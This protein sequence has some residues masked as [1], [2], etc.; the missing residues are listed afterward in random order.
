MAQNQ[1][2]LVFAGD[3][4]KLARSFKHVDTMAKGTEGN[5]EKSSKRIGGALKTLGA[6]AATGLAVASTAL[7]GFGAASVNSARDLAETQSAVGVVFGKTSSA[8]LAF[9]VA[10][11]KTL[12]QSQTQ[13]LDAANT[14]ATFGKSA[15]L[16]GD[17]LVG[18]STKMVGLASDMASFKNTTPQEAIE[19]I[20]S[21]L[22]GE[23]EP[24]RRYG[25]LLD[26]ATLRQEAL[27][28][29]L[30]KTTKT[31]LTPQQRVLAAQ[32][33]ILKQTSDAQGDFARTSGGLANQQRIAAAAVTNLKTRIGTAL[34]P[35]VTAL[36]VTFNAKLIPVLNDL[37][38]R[39]G[40]AVTAFFADAA[41]K[42]GPLADRLGSVDWSRF[43][44]TL[45]DALGRVG[46]QLRELGAAGGQGLWDTLKVGAVVLKFLA[47]HSDLLAKALPAIV[48]GF[49]LVKGA[50]AAAN[51]VSLASIPLR[52]AEV[53]ASFGMRGALRAHTVALR[54]NTVAARLSA[55][56]TVA[57]TT[58][59]TGG[60]L[61]RTRAIAS[62]V[63]HRV[64]SIASTAV[65]WLWAAATTA[66][67]VAMRFALGP[68]GLI[69]T[70]IALLVGAI[71]WV[72]T[73]TTWFQT[74]WKF[75]WGG[76]KSA[77]VAV[78]EWIKALPGNIGKAFANLANIITTPWRI[79]FNS[80]ARLWNNT[81]GGLS[82]RVPDWIPGVGGKGFDV[83]NIPTFHSGGVV[84]GPPGA[85]VLTLLQAGERVT[86]A[87]SGGGTAIVVSGG[88]GTSTERAIV[89]L[90]LHLIRTGKLQLTVQN[91]RVAV[92][93]G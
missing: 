58:A 54:E 45:A 44:N 61:A 31:A 16:S 23:S 36:A 15:G 49:L 34:L 18:F 47:D 22:R 26:D 2:T 4:D 1:V 25:V 19:A 88:G 90:I 13:A 38:T 62:M 17:K 72:A 92:G 71:I 91:G 66:L 11:D 50:Q 60:I 80:I 76:I 81:V 12:G 93:H 27:R 59:T 24:I 29:G 10:A 35:V 63:A 3:T 57:D 6:V 85:E 51:V 8:V 74:A 7:I 82:F 43:G 73:K 86:P 20:G 67:G 87:G 52:A 55:G 78:W 75:A 39:H 30:V 33:A 5:V 9:G 46:P 42:V 14:F 84:P 48:A 37:W 64:A 56:A 28:L 69:I 83:P 65:T 21:A 77:A 40:P 68:V 32:A 41:T 89:T 53:A 79:A 70:G